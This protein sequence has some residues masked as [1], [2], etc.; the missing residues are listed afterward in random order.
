MI[1]LNNTKLLLSCNITKQFNAVPAFL[2]FSLMVYWLKKIVG[3]YLVVQKSVYE[4][5]YLGNK[6]QLDKSELVVIWRENSSMPTKQ[7]VRFIELQSKLIKKGD[8]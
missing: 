8:P 5:R 3:V 2:R 1:F 6:V 7:R 4:L